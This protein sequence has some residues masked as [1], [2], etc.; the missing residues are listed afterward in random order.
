MGFKTTFAAV[1]VS[2]LLFTTN[3]M[4]LPTDG[5][6]RLA[7][8]YPERPVPQIGDSREY[9]LNYYG[10]PARTL[11]SNDAEVWDYG[12]FRVFLQNDKVAF[13]RVW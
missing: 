7:P 13:S 9:V 10:E 1:A 3:A 6:V 5:S 4:A 2:T 12:T 8:S 11:Y